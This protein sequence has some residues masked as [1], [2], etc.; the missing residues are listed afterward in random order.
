M[1]GLK[2]VG[3]GMGHFPNPNQ[4]TTFNAGKRFDDFVRSKSVVMELTS[5]DKKTP[6]RE[7]EKYLEL[8]E[9]VLDERA[10]ENEALWL[11]KLERYRGNGRISKDVQNYLERF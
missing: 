9:K 3:E 11:E 10:T 7:N 4:L 6:L 5:Y 2:F 8:K 1:E